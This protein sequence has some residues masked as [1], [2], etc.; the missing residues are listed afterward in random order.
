MNYT[1][2][3]QITIY[4]DNLLNQKLKKNHKTP[5]LHNPKKHKHLNQQSTSTTQ[6]DN[7][8]MSE[9]TKALYC[10]SPGKQPLLDNDVFNHLTTDEGNKIMYLNLS[11]NLTLK[12]KSHMYYFPLDFEKLTLDGLIDTGALTSAISEADLNKIKLLSNEAIKD[13]GP[14][15]N[16]QIMVANCPL[17]RPIG[18]VLLEFEVADFQYQKNFIV[19]KTLPNPLIGLC[20]LQRHNALF[21]IR[22][23]ILTF[24]YLS[25]QLRPENTTNTLAATPLLTETTYTLQPG[26]T[27]AISSK[28][29]HLT[30][31]NATGIVTPSSHMEEHESTFITSLLSTVNNNAV[32]YQVI[33]FSDVP[34]TLPVDTHMADFLVLTP[35]QI[36]HIKP[37]ATSTLTFMM[38]QHMENTDLYLNQLMKTNQSS[39]EQETY[40]FPTPEQPGNTTPYTP[41]QRIFDEL[42][43]LKQLEELNPNDKA[44]S[45]KKFL[46]HFDWTDT[47]LSPFENQLVKNI[48]VQHHDVF[49]RHRFDIGT[50]REFKVKLTPNDDRPA[51]SQSLPTPIN[52]KD[53]ITVE[54]AQL[55]RYGIITTLPCSKYASPIFAQRKP[56]GRLRPF[57][58]SAQNKQSHFTRLC[59]QQPPS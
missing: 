53:D 18:R 35:Q 17:E 4:Y 30:N 5:S 16:F 42:T 15:P 57:G 36:K 46:D 24:P 12:K 11:T 26:E 52:L 25:M 31:H 8:T 51:Y 21:D 47:T 34:Y 50:N 9:L 58:G 32:G 55:H 40:W 49:A 19:M 29:P 20:F 39:E 41:K 28:M 23:G 10:A 13:T 37:V 22:Q 33:N 59:K 48:L 3:Q 56:N 38:H 54:L 27:L 43:E 14:A 44:E 1:R 7:E 2:M 45:R 6:I